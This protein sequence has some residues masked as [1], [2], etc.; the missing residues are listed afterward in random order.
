[1]PVDELPRWKMSPGQI[2]EA[3]VAWTRMATVGLPC[4]ERPTRIPEAGLC[5]VSVLAWITFWKVNGVEMDLVNDVAD[6]GLFGR[7]LLSRS[8]A[9]SDDG[10][11]L[12]LPVLNVAVQYVDGFLSIR[13]PHHRHVRSHTG[14]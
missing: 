12:L 13:R 10:V 3:V 2:Q 7:G 11:S 1:M 9:L 4:S 6:V 8:C 14:P 5:L